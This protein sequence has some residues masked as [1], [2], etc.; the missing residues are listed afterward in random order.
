MDSC[1]D[2]EYYN[3]ANFWFFSY[4]IYCTNRLPVDVPQPENFSIYANS[5]GEK[6][7]LVAKYD[8]IP[9]IIA[10]YNGHGYAAFTFTYFSTINVIV[11][12]ALTEDGSNE[13]IESRGQWITRILIQQNVNNIVRELISFLYVIYLSSL[14]LIFIFT[15]IYP[16]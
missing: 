8:Q 7:Y 3:S 14:M 9:T 1:V 10:N 12:N 13:L 5:Q 4:G 6:G 2:F 11:Q 15:V 16:S